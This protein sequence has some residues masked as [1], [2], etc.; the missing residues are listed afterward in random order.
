VL[1]AAV[2][3]VLGKALAKA[4]QDRYGSVREFASGLMAAFRLRGSIDHWAS[5][6]QAE[7]D[8]ALRSAGMM[9][10]GGSNQAT[11]RMQASEAGVLRLQSADSLP[12]AEGSDSR[13]GRA[14]AWLA[15]CFCVVLA[16]GLMAWWLR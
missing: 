14:A 16:G 3:A 11:L 15:V 10:D 1:P 7:V 12:R 8:A 9:Q 13:R 2:D 4:K 5:A 6:S